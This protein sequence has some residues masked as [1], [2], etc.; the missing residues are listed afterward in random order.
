[1][2]PRFEIQ[3]CAHV[4]AD[5]RTSSS[6]RALTHGEKIR[7]E[8]IASV[9]RR[10]QFLAGR[11]L[12]KKMLAEARGGSPEDWHIDADT[13]TKPGVV[14]HSLQLSISHSGSYVACCVAEHAA[15][16]D[17]E[18]F[19]RLR[20]VA[21]MATLV[22]SGP[23]QDALRALQGDALTQH[24]F[25]LWTCKE[26]RLKQLGASFDVNALRAL[27]MA[28]VEAADAHVGTWRFLGQQNVMLSLAVKGLSRLHARWP[29]H[30]VVSPTQWHRYIEFA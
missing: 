2:D 29:E 6:E 10:E 17:V 24:F 27:H 13:Q 8:T 26:A 19:D 15:G 23:E 18:C 1:M 9:R 14:G 5:W 7:L 25:Q 11:W 20:P 16:I 12:A 4:L 30:W 21:D 28:P 3:T 22:C